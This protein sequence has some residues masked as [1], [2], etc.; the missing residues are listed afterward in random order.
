MERATELETSVCRPDQ[1]PRARQQ[2][3]ARTWIVVTGA[4]FDTPIGSHPRRKCSLGAVPAGDGRA[5]RLGRGPARTTDPGRPAATSGAEEAVTDTDLSEGRAALLHLDLTSL[6]RLVAGLCLAKRRALVSV[7]RRQLFSA[8]ACRPRRQQVGDSSVTSTS[9][10]RIKRGS[11]RATGFSEGALVH[12]HEIGRHAHHLDGRA[13]LPRR[14][15]RARSMMTTRS[16]VP[17]HY[18]A[19]GYSTVSTRTAST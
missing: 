14:R 10:V 3:R 12:H 17:Q 2:N 15:T 11:N 16:P 18:P 19:R 13:E 7:D 4:R 6:D 5:R 1:A 8:A 9:T